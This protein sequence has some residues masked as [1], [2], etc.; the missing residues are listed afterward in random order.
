MKITVVHNDQIGESLEH[1]EETLT[2]LEVARR[3]IESCETFPTRDLS[4]HKVE[5]DR[6]F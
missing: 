5:W 1:G 6:R 3:T 2:D 4:V